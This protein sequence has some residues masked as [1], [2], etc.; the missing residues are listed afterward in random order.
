MFLPRGGLPL[1]AD[2]RMMSPTDAL[3]FASSGSVLPFVARPPVAGAPGESEKR[4][5]CIPVL[6]RA[7]GFLLALPAGAVPPSLLA[8]GNTGD[9]DAM[10]GPSTVLTVPAME[11]QE[12][13]AE[14]ATETSIEVLVVDFSDAAASYLEPFDPLSLEDPVPFSEEAPQVFPECRQLVALSK[15][16]VR[17]VEGE[18]VAF[19]SALEGEGEAPGPADPAEAPAATAKAKAKR[20]TTAQL[21]EQLGSISQLLPA[22]SDRLQDLAE[23]QKEL[24][25][26]VTVQA[27]APPAPGPAHKQ[28]F[29]LPTSKAAPAVSNPTQAFVSVLG[30]PPRSRPLPPAAAQGD[31]VPQPPPLDEDLPPG[32]TTAHA[33]AQQT[34]ALTQLVS[35]LIQASDG[36]GD[37]VGAPAPSGLSS[38]ASAKR[39]RLQAELAQRTGN[40]M[41]AVAQSGFRRSYPTEAMP[42]TLDEFRQEPRRFLF[43]HYLERH[44]GYQHQ[45]DL[46]LIMHMITQV[47]DLLMAGE[48]EGSLDLLALIMVCLEQAA[49]DHGKFEVGFTLSLFAEPPH[50]IFTNRGSPHNPRLRAFAPLCPATWATTALAFLKETDVILSRRQEASGQ[51]SSS[52]QALDEALPAAKKPPRKPRFPR[53]PKET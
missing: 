5:L 51:A 14:V 3:A 35:H 32:T 17:S 43:S 10:F 40:F 1:P 22:I 6:R 36:S 53:K 21:A 8:Q 29:A 23:R 47:A 20:V 37:F 16:W 48:V 26:K 18:R 41:L 13:G 33:L 31:V 11:E 25:T 39:E 7:G 15:S 12:D 45:R 50:Q 2:S 38:R 24:E 27:T 42:R 46:G 9:P 49:A 44:G 28:P 52:G 4:V 19:Y 30:P 34:A